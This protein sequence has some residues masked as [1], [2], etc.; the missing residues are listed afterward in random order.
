[1]K[2]IIHKWL[3]LNN[4]KQIFQ[5][6]YQTI[7]ILSEN[8]YQTTLHT[9]RAHFKQIYSQQCCYRYQAVLQTIFSPKFRHRNSNNRST[10]RGFLSIILLQHLLRSYQPITSNNRTFSE[11]YYQI[12]IKPFLMWNPDS[13]YQIIP[14]TFWEFSLSNYINC[15]IMLTSPEKNYQIIEFFFQNSYQLILTFSLH[16]FFRIYIDRYWYFQRVTAKL[17]QPF[18]TSY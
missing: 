3:L 9:F 10:L 15:E 12:I 4:T 16:T 2:I 18:Q 1:M 11:M 13:Y 7:Q 8:Y 14:N 6:S 17:N 5:S